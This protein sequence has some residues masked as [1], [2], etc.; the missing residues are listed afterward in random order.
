MQGRTQNLSAVLRLLAGFAVLSVLSGLLVAGIGIPVVGAVGTAAKGGVKAFTDLPSDFEINP[1]AQQS[2]IVDANDQVIA[3]P[4]DEN[5]IIVGLDQISP[6]MTKAQIAIEDS[7]FYTHGG[8]DL[9]GFT[10]AMLSNF[11]GGDVQGAST[12]T[13]QYVKI[14]LQE[15]ALRSGD[16]EAARAAVAKN[17]MRKLQELKYA[18]NVEENFTKDQ[19]LQGYLNLVYYGDQAYGVEAASQNYFGI[20]AKDLNLSQA[21]LLAGIVQQPGTFNPVQNPENAQARRDTVLN[22]MQELGSATPEEVAAAKAVPVSSMINRKP[23]KGVCHRSTQP[24]FCAY[25]MAWLE[26]SPHMAAL[27]A[28][29]AER[30]KNI[31]QSGLTIKTTLNP[32][33]Q[34]AAMERV[35]EAVPI[36][37]DQGLGGAATVIEPGTGKIIA[38]A[39]SSDFATN[40]VVWNADKQYGG[41]TYGWQFG[42]TAKV[43]ALVAA[44]ERGMPVDATIFAPQAS[45]TKP[46]VFTKDKVIDECGMDKPW[47]VENDYSVGGTMTLQKA[48]SQSI[49][50]AFAE[51]VLSLGGCSVRDVM[52]KMGLHASDGKPI[53]SVI[54]AITL[55][56][57]TTTPMTLASSMATLA[58]RG[59]YC[60]PFPVTAILTADKQEIQIPKSACNQVVAPE[61]A[62]G[63]N[64]LL[65]GP[66]NN[67]TAAGVWN[68]SR[69]AAG[70]TGTTNNHNQSW[71][72]G[73]TPQLST[74]VWIGNIVPADANGNAYTLNGKRFGSYGYRGS[75]FGGTIAAPVWAKI[76]A[77]ASEGLP[78]VPFTEPTKAVQS[79][80]QVTIPKVSGMTQARAIEALKAV[81]LTGYVQG[82]VASGVRRGLVVGTNPR[83]RAI[84]GSS[85]GLL[86]SS[87]SPPAPKPAPAPA[88][89]APE[90]SPPPSTTA[91]GPTNPGNGNGRGRGNGP[92]P[93]PNRSP[94]I[95]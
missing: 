6:W 62:D 61:V 5:R 26:K 36:G 13:Q 31:N 37:D 59:V 43:Y 45:P 93:P 27:G 38:M 65:Q 34:Q 4:Y 69:P 8:L 30:L 70:K 84:K 16:K 72:A 88:E 25:V 71:F 66:L 57:G 81:G 11:S 21:A 76:M 78:I 56:A 47:E 63:V 75:V 12:L 44:L 17:Y 28:T 90:P 40:Q 23:A 91:T 3:N 94:S 87:G 52:T 89:P 55:G 58:A 41:G 86:L 22:R 67:G 92:K 20:P 53:E 46:A 80:E 51:L 74:A 83:G 85:V 39:Q 79:G 7:R 42:S 33:V 73:Y 54:S 77:Q 19:I 2:K 9:R 60:E 18:M 35:T 29:P 64:K 68:Q 50:T 82:Q 15:N 10:R 49:N 24:Y 95:G 48:T 14:T 1:L 32:A